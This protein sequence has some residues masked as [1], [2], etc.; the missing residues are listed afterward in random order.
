M[1]IYINKILLSLNKRKTNMRLLTFTC[2]VS[3]FHT[4]RSGTPLLV[5]LKSLANRSQIPHSKLFPIQAT[6]P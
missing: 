1:F 4:T 2:K 5:N 6:K 3:G